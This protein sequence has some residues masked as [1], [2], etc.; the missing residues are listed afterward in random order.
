MPHPSNVIT[1]TG[2]KKIISDRWDQNYIEKLDDKQKEEM[3]MSSGLNNL[4][5]TILERKMIHD[6]VEV[7]KVDI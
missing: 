7:I 2:E 5:Y 3:I 4:E 1:Y 6:V